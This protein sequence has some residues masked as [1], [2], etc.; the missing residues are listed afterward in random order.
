VGGQR[1]QFVQ[2][3]GVLPVSGQGTAFLPRQLAQ[4]P[5]EGIGAPGDVLRAGPAGQ[6]VDPALVG[7]PQGAQQG[8]L[9]FV[10]GAG[11]VPQS[12][13]PLATAPQFDPRFLNAFGVSPFFGGGVGPWWG[14]TIP[15]TPVYNR[16]INQMGV[17]TSP[18]TATAGVPTL[19]ISS[20]PTAIPRQ[21]AR[22]VFG[23]TEP[24]M[25]VSRPA[26]RVAGQRQEIGGQAQDPQEARLVSRV[27]SMM[28]NDRPLYGGTVTQV[29]ATA[30]QVRYQPNGTTRTERFG[31]GEVFFFN[32]GGELTSAA[33]GAPML[34]V[35]D[36]VLV[37]GPRERAGA[38]SG[39]ETRIGGF[40]VT[41]PGTRR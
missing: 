7:T 8:P 41:E 33:T 13:F 36:S 17:L 34:S 23:T 27:R 30:A 10:P 32:D 22:V 9:Q 31:L 12:A 18:T 21:R 6:I 1:F 35:G 20:F 37:P 25:G 3:V 2:N 28:L 29:G 40:R 11:F 24:N 14:G 39:E 38:A 16:P 4:T 26:Q 5:G 15:L 19:G